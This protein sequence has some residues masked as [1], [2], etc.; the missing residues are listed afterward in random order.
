MGTESSENGLFVFKHL[1]YELIDVLFVTILA[2]EKLSPGKW[3]SYDLT[4]AAIGKGIE[5]IFPK[6]LKD[7]FPK[8]WETEDDDKA[9]LK[10]SL[11]FPLIKRHLAVDDKNNAVME[12]GNYIKKNE[13]TYRLKDNVSFIKLSYELT[14][15]TETLKHIQSHIDVMQNLIKENE[16]I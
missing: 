5:G 15:L 9:L 10:M 1:I 16:K 8:I 4:L 14:Q 6:K 11:F 13:R 2:R 7:D 3:E 12:L